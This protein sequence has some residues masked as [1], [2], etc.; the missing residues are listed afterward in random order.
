MMHTNLELVALSVVL[1]LQAGA[2]LFSRKN[3]ELLR[4]S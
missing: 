3:C 4:T 2:C 1:C